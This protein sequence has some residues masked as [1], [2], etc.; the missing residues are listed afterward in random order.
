MD[1]LINSIIG[2]SCHYSHWYGCQKRIQVCASPWV[3]VLHILFHSPLI[4]QAHNYCINNH[5]H[6]NGIYTKVSCK[7]QNCHGNHIHYQSN[8]GIDHGDI[9]LSDSLKHAIGNIGISIE[10]NGNDTKHHQ[11]SCC[12]LR[13]WEQKSCDRAGKNCK[14]YCTWN[15]NKHTDPGCAVDLIS[16]TVHVPLGILG[17][18]LRNHGCGGCACKRKGN[19]DQGHIITIFRIKACN[20]VMVNSLKALNTRIH[21][22]VNKAVYIVNKRAE[23]DRHY[24]ENDILHNL[25]SSFI[26]GMSVP[27]QSLF[28]ILSVYP[29][30]QKHEQQC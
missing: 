26:T 10:D 28:D 23:N 16:G 19:I 11:L 14:S 24:N 7:Q 6:Y 12:P 30:Y 27:C 4:Q 13:P 25:A 17:R 2:K 29:I 9:G 20:S 8:C 21:I 1:Q 22:T 15:G 3:F 18:N 5:C